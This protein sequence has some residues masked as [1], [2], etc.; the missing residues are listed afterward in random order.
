VSVLRRSEEVAVTED[1]VFAL[2]Q[3]RKSP[4]FTVVTVATLALGIGATTAIFSVVKRVLLDQLPYREPSQLVKIGEASP[5]TRVPETIDFTTAYDLRERSQSFQRMSLFRDGGGAIVE[6][7]EPELLSGIRVGYDYFDTLGARMELG[8][9]FKPEEDTPETRYEA[10]LSHGLWLRRFGGDP[11]I[12]GR[13]IRMN[14]RSYLVVGVLPEN[15]RPFTRSGE[16]DTPEIYTPLGYDLKL[17]QACRGCQHLQMVGR[18]KPGVTVEQANAELNGILRDIIR[19][20]PKEYAEN[21]GIRMLPVQD[22][23]VGRVSTALWVLLAAV[24]FVLLIACANVAHLSLARATSREPEMAV[25]AALGA[26]RSRLLRQLLVENLLI[27][28]IGGGLGV[29]LAFWGIS[30]LTRLAPAD[31]PRVEDI[32]IDMPVMLFACFTSLLTGVLFGIAPALRAARTDPGEAL[33]GSSRTT[34]SRAHTTYRS[35][36]LVVEMALAFTLLAGASLLGKSLLK[37]LNV[38]PGYDPHNVLTAGVYPYGARYKNA[39]AELA[40]YDQAMQRLRAIPG[41]EGAAMVSTLPMASVD[42][43]GLHIQDRPLQNES[44]APSPDTYAVSPDYFSVMGIPLKHGRLFSDT[45]RAGQ[46]DVALIS[47]SC[48]RAV[49][50]DEDPIG[51]HI[52]LGGRYNDKPWLTI[53]GIV[54]DVR[55]Y[56]LDQPS[57]MEAYISE[58]QRVDFGF[59]LVVRTTGDPRL[60]EGAV[61]QA[62]LAVDPSLPIHHVRPLQDYVARSLA[63]RRYTLL[64]LGLF[65]ALAILL[66]AVGLYGVISYTVTL[67]TRELGIRMALGAARRDVQ[68]MV[69]RQGLTVVAVGLLSGLGISF[70][71]ARFLS[72]LLFQV[73]PN[74]VGL[75]LLDAVILALVALLANYLPAARASRIEPMEA[76][77]YE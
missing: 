62:F 38:D 21:T 36:L 4:L 41:I 49:F 57:R 26:Q 20:H 1:L 39:D 13:N 69:L 58:A 46:P 31:L 33:K 65:G 59:N 43:R 22:Y 12:V 44:E 54:G 71:L 14:D 27:A 67:R 24:G 76:L 60:M 56:G 48:A 75:A 3:F 10:I 23:V 30:A 40:Y 17:P 55:Q 72:S 16:T 2:R 9:T 47:E 7:G 34:D 45:D 53:V 61:R 15:F 18:M 28:C 35:A 77:R 68:K 52:Q 50:G 8:R 29:L 66:A 51:R 25:R 42:R 6:N 5:D 11:A 19:E 73:R 32:R 74:D 64:L 70:L 63:T 37:L